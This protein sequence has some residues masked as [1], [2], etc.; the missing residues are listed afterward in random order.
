MIQL[1]INVSLL[2]FVLIML[3]A[4]EECLNGID[5]ELAAIR[6]EMNLFLASNATFNL[7]AGDLK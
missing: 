6:N 7:N 4:A 5:R 3:L 2:S 1:L